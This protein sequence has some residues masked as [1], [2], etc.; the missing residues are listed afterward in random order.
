[1]CLRLLARRQV[2]FLFLS[3]YYF[4]VIVVIA[5]VLPSLLSPIHLA[6]SPR[7]PA[8]S[9]RRASETIPHAR[10]PRSS[11][12][13]TSG[14]GHRHLRRLVLPL[15]SPSVS[16]CCSCLCSVRYAYLCS[17]R[18]RRIPA[19][20]Q[21]VYCVR[22]TPLSALCPKP[23]D[24][25]RRSPSLASTD[26]VV[27][28]LFAHPHPTSPSRKNAACEDACEVA[29][30]LRACLP[31]FELRPEIRP[32]RDPSVPPFPTPPSFLCMCTHAST[33][34]GFLPEQAN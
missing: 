32:R 29:L 30:S 13:P 24:I 25:V 2:L 5:V 9:P 8:S 26:Q 14:N 12:Y 27:S 21:Y 6:A 4:F 34:L 7:P 16:S 20:G 17:V 22:N 28:N 23:L 1:M 19:S 3:L 18:L 10:C 11:K 31:V 15:A 33:S